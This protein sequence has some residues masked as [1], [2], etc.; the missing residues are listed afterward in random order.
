MAGGICRE[1]GIAALA[2]EPEQTPGQGAEG[3]LAELDLYARKGNE[4]LGIEVK[5]SSAPAVT[6]SMRHALRDLNLDELMVVHAGDSSCPLAERIRAVSAHR[7]ITD[8]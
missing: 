8:L 7:L 1:G 6:P 5:L 2:C 4:R 3:V